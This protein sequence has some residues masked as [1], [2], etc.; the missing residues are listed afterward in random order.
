MWCK[1]HE[2]RRPKLCIEFLFEDEILFV[3]LWVH[4]RKVDDDAEAAHAVAHDKDP[5]NKA[6]RQ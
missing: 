5:F 1:H 6:T 2:Y 4:N 3:E